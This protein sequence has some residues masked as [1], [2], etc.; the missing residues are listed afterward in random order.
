ML[1]LNNTIKVLFMNGFV[2][3]TGMYVAKLYEFNATVLFLPEH[4][5]HIAMPQRY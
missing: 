4:F 1:N 5:Y 2:L 3:L